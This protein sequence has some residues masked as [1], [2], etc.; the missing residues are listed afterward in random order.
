MYRLLEEALKAM[1]TSLPLVQVCGTAVLHTHTCL[2]LFRQ[3][4]HLACLQ[5]TWCPSV[6]CGCRRDG[7]PH[8]LSSGRVQ[9]SRISVSLPAR[10]V[11]VLQ[12]LHHPAMRDR[13]WKMLMQT[14][15]K[16][17]TMDEKFCL[18]DLLALELHNYVDACRCA[19]DLASA[20]VVTVASC[21]RV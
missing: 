18:G 13:H 21:P 15:G 11:A 17:F 12:D 7:C 3:P 20:A 10:R 4:P 8:V 9:L 16:H 6:W 14:T 2:L 5:Q 19:A 1:L